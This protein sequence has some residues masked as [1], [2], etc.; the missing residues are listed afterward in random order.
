MSALSPESVALQ[1]LAGLDE[2]LITYITSILDDMTVDERK[3]SDALNESISPFLIDSEFVDSE[4][5]ALACCRKMSVSFGGSGYKSSKVEEEDETPMLLAAPMKMKDTSGYAKQKHTFGGAVFAKATGQ[6]FDDKSSTGGGFGIGGGGNSNSN[7]EASAMPTTQKQVR[8]M[9][10]ENE[11]VQ[12]IMRIEAAARQ[13]EEAELS[14]ARLAAIKASRLLGR[15]SVTGVNIERFSIPHPSGTSD[16]LT[17]VSLV[18]AP[19]RRYGTFKNSNSRI[20]CISFCSNP[21][22][23]LRGSFSR[24]VI[25]DL[26]QSDYEVIVEQLQNS[27]RVIAK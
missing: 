22:N 16:L 6:D 14:R 2:D 12:K 10:R 24:K 21:S 23:I 3:S 7:Y 4:E 17:D 8:Q 1:H 5:A 20:L 11:R 15:A 13:A 27:Y 26:M 18:L 19:G 25:T 9:R